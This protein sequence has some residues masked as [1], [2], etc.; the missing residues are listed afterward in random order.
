MS[1]LRPSLFSPWRD[2]AS[3]ANLVD[4]DT[5]EELQKKDPLGIQIW[6]LYSKTKNSLPNQERM[7]NLSWRM[8]SMNLKK[9]Q[10]EHTRS[11]PQCLAEVVHPD[12]HMRNSRL[13][14][15][16]VS[17]TP[18]TSKP[19]GIAQLRQQ[20]SANEQHDHMNMDDFILPNS[21]ASPANISRSPSVEK[22]L[23]TATAI[24]SA[25]PIKKQNEL[26]DQSFPHSLPLQAP[27]QSN[28]TGEFGYVQRY[29]RKTSID[30]RRVSTVRICS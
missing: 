13:N 10:D 27:L 28:M 12:S 26:R 21:V 16:R 15:R 17:A 19:S 9:Q 8:M 14:E 3:T 30:E 24:A 23:G 18:A 20:S 2:D 5:P 1:V 6:K 11:V 22:N 25:I 4:A 7:G 29:V